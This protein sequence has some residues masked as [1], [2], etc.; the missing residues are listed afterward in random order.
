MLQ[1]HH[2]ALDEIYAELLQRIELDAQRDLQI[3][4]MEAQQTEMLQILR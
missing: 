1:V 2:P 3:Q 4:N